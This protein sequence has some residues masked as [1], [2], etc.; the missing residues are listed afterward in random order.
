MKRKGK[1]VPM[2]ELEEMITKHD[3]DKDGKIDFEDFIGMMH[4]TDGGGGEL[5]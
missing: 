2:G 4:A 3:K 1:E 5:E